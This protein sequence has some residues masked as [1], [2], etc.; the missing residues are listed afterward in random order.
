MRLGAPA[1]IRRRGRAKVFGQESFHA[2]R[3]L[4]RIDGKWGGVSRLWYNPELFGSGGGGE[5]LMSIGRRHQRVVGAVDYHQRASAELGC[6]LG[7][8]EVSARAPGHR[9]E[10]PQNR[11]VEQ[12]ME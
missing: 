1:L 7:W 4:P 10:F 6:R 2:L 11:T 3:V 8:R 9:P 12:R 5:D